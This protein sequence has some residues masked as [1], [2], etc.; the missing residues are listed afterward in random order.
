MLVEQLGSHTNR[1]KLITEKQHC[2][3]FKGERETV[4]ISIAVKV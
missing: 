2:T 4:S 1:A 3:R